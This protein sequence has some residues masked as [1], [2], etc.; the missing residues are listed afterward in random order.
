MVSN[1]SFRSWSRKVIISRIGIARVRF[2]GTGDPTSVERLGIALEQEADYHERLP[3][4]VRIALKYF[5]PKRSL[6]LS[7]D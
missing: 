1:T 2:N 6:G 5:A 7:C 4:G 3:I